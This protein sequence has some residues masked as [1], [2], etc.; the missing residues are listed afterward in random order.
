MKRWILL[1]A[2]VVALSTAATVALQYVQVEP[3]S[4]SPQF[5]V[6]ENQPGPKPWVEVLGDLTYKFDA[7]P[8]HDKFS[9]DWVIKNKG[10]GDLHLHLNATTCSCTVAEFPDHT[11]SKD[12]T[13]KPGGETRL[14]LTFDTKEFEGPYAKSATVGTNDPK[15]PEI[16]FAAEG[17]VFPAVVFFPPERTIG[18]SSIPNDVEHPAAV[19][20]FSP[21]RPNLK[22]K[23]ITSS[24]PDLIVADAVPL[25]KEEQAQIKAKG[26]GYRL[27]IRVKPGL[28]LGF[29]RDEIEIETDHPKQPKTKLT[30]TGKV[31]GPIA[32]VPEHLR[33]HNISGRRGGSGQMTLMVR[34]FRDTKFEVEKKPE[35]LLVDISPTGGDSKAGKYK[36][37]VT[38]PP[39]TSPGEIE[40]TIILKTDHPQASV[41][42][43]PIDVFILGPS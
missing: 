10:D 13:V 1:A 31:V 24:K 20:M 28:P 15:H 12:I 25:T 35:K 9:N 8:Q 6:V 29:F 2:L 27:S 18:F 19:A 26:G 16:T 30:V 32:L 37:T 41:V 4:D 22:I 38:I 5:P 21:D 17:K 34:G 40:D 33:L 42:K 23:K 3:K 43:I 39:G 14:H 36:L 7:K 11:K